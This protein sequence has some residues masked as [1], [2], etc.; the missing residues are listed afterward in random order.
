[1]NAIIKVETQFKFMKLFVKLACGVLVVTALAKLL[2]VV[3][4][5]RI[6][7]Q[8]DPL[9]GSLTNRQV[10]FLA[11]GMELGV[12]ALVW[13]GVSWL[14][15]VGFIAWVSTVFLIYRGG[16]W[17]GGHEGSCKCLGNLSQILGLSAGMMDGIM[18]GVL[19]FLVVGSYFYLGKMLW[20]AR[21]GSPSAVSTE[22]CA[23]ASAE[24]IATTAP[25]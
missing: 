4:E 14:L 23:A 16:L 7:A 6:L 15:R 21:T 24:H 25:K 18:K 12:V 20:A 19:A 1:V 5:S 8:P 9:L 13:S 2:M 11:A 10:L 22:S 17:A 3:G